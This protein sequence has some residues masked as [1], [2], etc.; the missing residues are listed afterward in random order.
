MTE[1]LKKV[2][3]C[4]LCGKPCGEIQGFKLHLRG[5]HGLTGIPEDELTQYIEEIREGTYTEVQK[6]KENTLKKLS[7]RKIKSEIKDVV[8]KTKEEIKTSDIASGNT[9]QDR[10]NRRE[11]KR[12]SFLDKH[13]KI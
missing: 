12:K 10:V 8:E 9:Y 7:E 11:Q 3:I 1:K 6:F 4:K 13:R 5:K 2:V